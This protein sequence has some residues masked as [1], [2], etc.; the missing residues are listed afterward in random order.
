MVS[1]SDLHPTETN[2]V[3]FL[4]GCRHEYLSCLSLCNLCNLLSTVGSIAF[5]LNTHFSHLKKRDY[6]PNSLS[7]N[8]LG[9]TVNTKSE[10]LEWDQGVYI[11]PRLPNDSAA[12][13]D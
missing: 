11:L 6:F 7:G 9:C 13:P 3:R 5:S 12:D 1:I 8:H 4:T 2:S 10:S